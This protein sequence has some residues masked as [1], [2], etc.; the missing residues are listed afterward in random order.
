MPSV[1]CHLIKKELPK[2]VEGSKVSFPL[3]SVV[4]YAR[5]RA[6]LLLTAERADRWRNN[7]FFS[8]FMLIICQS[9]EWWALTFLSLLIPIS[10]ERFLSA[11]PPPPQSGATAS[12]F[13]FLIKPSWCIGIPVFN[14][15]ARSGDSHLIGAVAMRWP[16][17]L[18]G[19]EIKRD[20]FDTD[21]SQSDWLPVLLLPA[22]LAVNR[23]LIC[24]AD[25]TQNCLWKAF[26]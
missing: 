6:R 1:I 19:R 17:H 18:T 25:Y 8:S 5:D 2:E 11:A 13:F 22:T 14:H 7:M 23:S 9:F 12:F 15:T 4:S 21:C 10:E 26:L 16:W 3:K 20:C 24:V